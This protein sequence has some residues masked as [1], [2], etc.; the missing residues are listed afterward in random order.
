MS[1]IIFQKRHIASFGPAL[2]L[3]GLLLLLLGALSCSR[4]N[5]MGS[6]RGQWQIQSIQ[7]IGQAPEYPRNPEYYISFDQGMIQLTN[8]EIGEFTD[9]PWYCGEVT[10]EYPEYTFNF[11][12]NLSLTQIAMLS[13]WG[14]DENPV[15]AEIL[16]LD[17]NSLII[18]IGDNK[19]TLRRY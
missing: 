11:P 9:V 6:L 1:G 18:N 7:R 10:G 2:A 16:T 4:S 12:Y 19:L 15:G 17:N 14:I 8:T 5:T 3:I 13:P